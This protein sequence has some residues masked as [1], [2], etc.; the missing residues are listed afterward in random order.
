MRGK[1]D[2]QVLCPL[3]RHPT[4]A[5]SKLSETW[6][7][8]KALHLSQGHRCVSV[9]PLEQTPS[10]SEKVL[11]TRMGPAEDRWPD[12]EALP[13]AEM[14]WLWYPHCAHSLAGGSQKVWPRVSTA[15]GQKGQLLAAVLCSRPPGE[16]PV[17]HGLP[18]SVTHDAPW[19]FCLIPLFPYL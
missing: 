14:T 5:E 15:V 16:R 1:V 2:M 8:P 10:S 3:T 12:G 18:P 4:R 9:G 17:T 11:A 6:S 19:E 13:R 7:F